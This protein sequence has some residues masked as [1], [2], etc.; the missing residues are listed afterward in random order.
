MTF[1]LA[2]FIFSSMIAGW[3]ACSAFAD[4]S[5]DGRFPVTSNLRA[6][7]AKIDITPE[8]TDGVIVTGHRRTV[9]G[10][11]DPLRAGVLVLDDG[12]TKAAIVTLDTIGAWDDMVKLAEGADGPIGETCTLAH[13]L[14][15]HCSWV[16]GTYVQGIRCTRGRSAASMRPHYAEEVR[17]WAYGRLMLSA[18]GF[19]QMDP[20]LREEE[21]ALRGYRRGYRV[22]CRRLAKKVADRARAS[23]V[24]L[25]PLM[26][27]MTQR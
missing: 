13:E 26:L 8:E 27:T 21:A 12:E 11:R 10:V 15:H 20:L 18:L 1:R 24:Q 4:E 25:P 2:I 22:R 3:Q 7:V 23:V 5:S 17:A 9:F 19:R 14:G 16:A 6:G